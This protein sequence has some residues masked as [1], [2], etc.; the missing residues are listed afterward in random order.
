MAAE[1][2]QLGEV[3][4]QR[5]GLRT[6][7][8]HLEDSAAAPIADRSDAWRA[9]LDLSLAEIR[10]AWAR[11]IAVTEAPDGLFEQ[12]RTDAPQL[13]PRIQR[14]HREHEDLQSALGSIT[15]DQ[16]TDPEGARELVIDLVAKLV[17]HRQHGADVIYE[18]YSVDVGGGG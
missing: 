11:H 6:A 13:S 16:P 5:S 12:I 10:S 15:D 3:R 14:L 1:F 17:R 9:E 4:D 18:A 7:M 2:P 8:I